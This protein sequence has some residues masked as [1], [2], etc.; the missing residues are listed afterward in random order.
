M[1]LEWHPR[2]G[3]SEIGQLIFCK[4]TDQSPQEKIVEQ[5]SNGVI[6]PKSHITVIMCYK[7]TIEKEFCRPLKK[8]DPWKNMLLGLS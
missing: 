3:L 7:H 2:R 4:S 5:W 1:D 8:I 6:L